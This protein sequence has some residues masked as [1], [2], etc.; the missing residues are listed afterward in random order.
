MAISA[1]AD[2]P[3]AIRIRLVEIIRLRS[4]HRTSIFVAYASA[5][6]FLDAPQ[7]STKGRLRRRREVADLISEGFRSN[8]FFG[9]YDGR[10]VVQL[11]TE[12]DQQHC[13]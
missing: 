11:T 1:V 6:T 10:E 7:Q 8:I 5:F 13:Q 2:P 9:V 3:V 4:L 12:S